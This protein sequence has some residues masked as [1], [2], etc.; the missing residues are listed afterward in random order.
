M[1]LLSL[2]LIAA[3]TL[4]FT[5]AN[6]LPIIAPD[7]SSVSKPLDVSRDSKTLSRSLT[8]VNEDDEEDQ[9]EERGGVNFGSLT[10]VFKSSSKTKKAT[11]VALAAEKQKNFKTYGKILAY[12][13][14]LYPAMATWRTEGLSVTKVYNE[15]IAAG[16]TVDE[17]RTVFKRYSTYLQETMHIVKTA[18]DLEI[19]QMR[20]MFKDIVN[21]NDALYKNMAQWRKDGV[22][23]SWIYHQMTT[24]G[25]RP[26]GEANSVFNSYSNYLQS[27]MFK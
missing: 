11:Q 19:S 18:K 6:A 23:A 3:S 5:T 22:S 8:T 24:I 17:A 4:G 14:V 15:M 7:Q 21:S 1:R 16:R 27:M 20:Q 9:E 25:G 13:H 26:V 12:D 2:L 10:K